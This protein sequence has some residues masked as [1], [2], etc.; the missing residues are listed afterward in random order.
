MTEKANTFIGISGWTYAPWRGVFYP[1]GLAAKDEL[2]YAASKFRSI[3]INGTFYRLQN[4]KSYEK[5]YANT[6]EDFVFS[7]KG[8]R[9]ISHVRRLKE[10]KQP[11]ANFLASGPLCLKEKLGCF[12]WQFPPFVKLKDTRFED[13]FAL[14]PKS[15]GEAQILAKGHDDFVKDKA[16]TEIDVDRPLHHAFE[17]RHHSF[18]NED[19]LGL[20]Q[21]HNVSLVLADGESGETPNWRP[22]SDNLYVRLHGTHPDYDDGYTEKALDLWCTRIKGWQRHLSVDA[23]SGFRRIWVYFDNDMKAKAPENAQALRSRLTEEPLA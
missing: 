4:P 9:Y 18:F 22:T 14:L 6:P 1:K 16:F 12:L 5:W 7:I 19:F 2:G 3:E 23:E 10:I 21:S 13:F 17:F 11:L 15:S 20:M 8:S